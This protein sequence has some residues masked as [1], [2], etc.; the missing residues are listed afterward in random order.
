MGVHTPS[1]SIYLSIHLFMFIFLCACM[2][3][4]VCVC[5]C[6]QFLNQLLEDEVRT[7]QLG[8]Q[9][10][11]LDD[12]LEGE[13]D[14]GS[15]ENVRRIVPGDVRAITPSPCIHAQ[16]QISIHTLTDSEREREPYTHTHIH[17]LSWTYAHMCVFFWL[18]THTGRTVVD[19]MGCTV[20]HDVRRARALVRRVALHKRRV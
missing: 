9:P 17:L 8:A 16:K 10:A 4:W 6:V 11:R 12:D 1:L 3:L 7:L 18:S 13:D 20:G 15:N 5:V 19:W 2:C 14:S